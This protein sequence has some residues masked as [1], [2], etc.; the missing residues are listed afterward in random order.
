MKD[1]AAQHNSGSDARP[2][3]RR[4]QMSRAAV[5]TGDSLVAQVR[6]VTV[7][8]A[9]TIASASETC[10]VLPTTG[11]CSTDVSGRGGGGTCLV[12]VE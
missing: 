10:V 5:A 1:R 8:F 2:L 3:L 6:S 11:V 7:R 9:G 12:F 4:R